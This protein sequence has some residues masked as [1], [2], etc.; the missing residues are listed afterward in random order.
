MK[1][2]MEEYDNKFGSKENLNLVINTLLYI[3]QDYYY[4]GEANV[5]IKNLTK[6]NH[7]LKNLNK[8]DLSSVIAVVVLLIN[9]KKCCMKW[10]C[11]LLDKDVWICIAK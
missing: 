4:N 9:L 7:F 6:K 5:V 11:V 10:S 3:I 2:F 8:M 1:D